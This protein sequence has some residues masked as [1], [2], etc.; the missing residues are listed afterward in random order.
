MTNQTIENMIQ[1]GSIRHFDSSRPIPQEMLENI[2]KAAQQSPT[3]VAGQQYSIIVIDDNEKKQMITNSTISS[4]GVPMTFIQEAPIFLLFVM[5]CNKINIALEYENANPELFNSFENLLIGTVD[6]GIAAEAVTVAAES[7][8]LGT[9]MV[10]ALRKMT[11]TLIK[12]FNLPPYT[13]PLLGLAI[14]YPSTENKKQSTPRLPLESLLHKNIYEQKDF[15]KY[16]ESYNKIMKEHFSVKRN[17][18]LT[19]TEYVSKVYSKSFN[20]ELLQLYRNQGFYF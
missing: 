13:F 14:G 4:A 10:G 20:K 15:K 17:V 5:D 12:E 3:Y 1:R 2:F 9:V 7:F 18:D 11:S 8:G 6:I 16:F 19:W